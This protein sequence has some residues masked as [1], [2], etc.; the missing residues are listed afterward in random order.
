MAFGQALKEFLVGRPERYDQVQQYNPQQ[1]QALQGLLQQA[2]GRLGQRQQFSFD[3]IAQQART[4]FGQQ[5][6]PSIAER[7]SGLGAGAQR[8]SAFGQTLGQAGAGLEGQLAAQGAQFGM[9]GQGMEDQLLQSL[10]GLGLKPQFENI[11]RPS[12][13]GFLQNAASQGLQAGMKLLTGGLL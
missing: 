13:Q 3:P 11:Y 7:F 10:L 1:Q 5:T 8:S 4:Q 9:Q 2:L 6:V 12:Q